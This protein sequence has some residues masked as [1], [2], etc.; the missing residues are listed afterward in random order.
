MCASDTIWI[1]ELT[2]IHKNI[3]SVLNLHAQELTL[4]LKII[5]ECDSVTDK[6]NN[7]RFE[8]FEIHYH[9]SSHR[10]CCDT[11]DNVYLDLPNCCY[12]IYIIV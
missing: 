4:I 7:T 6:N 2:L 5:S 10:T 1:T 3:R 11:S 12:S 8:D 9:S